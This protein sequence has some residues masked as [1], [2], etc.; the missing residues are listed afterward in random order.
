MCAV[1]WSTVAVVWFSYSDDR[2]LET[3]VF[4]RRNRHGSNVRSNGVLES[5]ECMKITNARALSTK[6]NSMLI[7]VQVKCTCVA[8]G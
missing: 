8:M 2:D 3:D 7:T 6:L 4:D 5:H 1:Q